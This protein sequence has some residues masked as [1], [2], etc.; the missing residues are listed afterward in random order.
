M[1]RLDD[2]TALLESSTAKISGHMT[3]IN[4]LQSQVNSWAAEVT[5]LYNRW[6]AIADNAFN[7]NRRNTAENEYNV[8]VGRH[9]DYTNALNN[10][11]VK[12]ADEQLSKSKK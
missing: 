8:A 3:Q 7:R 9:R 1:S 10:E 5:R 4:S 6:Q 12:L 11:R 2:L